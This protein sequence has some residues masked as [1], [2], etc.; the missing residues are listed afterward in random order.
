MHIFVALTRDGPK[1]C[2]TN[3]H[4]NKLN[5]K[6]FAAKEKGIIDCKNCT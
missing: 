6:F 2:L 4:K 3:G 1:K 5:D